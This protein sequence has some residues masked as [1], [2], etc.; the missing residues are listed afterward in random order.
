MWQGHLPSSVRGVLAVSEVKDL[1]HL[2][3]IAD[4]I[5]ETTRAIHVSEVQTSTSSSSENAFIIAELAKL[6]LKIRDMERERR[7]RRVNNSRRRSRSRSASRARMVTR[8]S[9]DSPDW[10]CFYHF[11]YRHR[12]K[13][14]IEPCA[15]KQSVD[16]EN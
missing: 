14:C 13:K 16:S 5:M 6:S 9:S 12:A 11:K 8:R 7:V 15:W 10:L 2:A 1:E 4:K 3:A